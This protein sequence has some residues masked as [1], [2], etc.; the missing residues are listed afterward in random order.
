MLRLVDTRLNIVKALNALHLQT[1]D[2]PPWTMTH[3]PAYMM[4][5]PTIGI[6]EALFAAAVY[7]NYARVSGGVQLDECLICV[8]Y[9]A[10]CQR[11]TVGL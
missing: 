2:V 9:S 7:P 6:L 11:P 3:T 1:I 4:N 8:V 10:A 5:V